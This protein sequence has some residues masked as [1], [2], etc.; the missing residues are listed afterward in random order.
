[1]SIVKKIEGI[2]LGV[3]MGDYTL[4]EGLVA[5]RKIDKAL[6]G[7]AHLRRKVQS[8]LRFFEGC[9]EAELDVVETEAGHAA[10]AEEEDVLFQMML[11]AGLVPPSPPI[12]PL[13]DRLWAEAVD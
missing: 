3:L 2:R 8:V 6:G 10:R 7:N 4:F 13:L 5:V 1:M 11:E 9:V 12:Q